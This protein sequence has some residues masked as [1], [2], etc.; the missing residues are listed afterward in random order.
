MQRTKGSA[1]S[2]PARPPASMTYTTPP[3]DEVPSIGMAAAG[4]LGSREVWIGSREVWIGSGEGGKEGVPGRTQ[5]S[6][7]CTP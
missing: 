3:D 4:V 7:A 2:A 5:A 6:L 1:S